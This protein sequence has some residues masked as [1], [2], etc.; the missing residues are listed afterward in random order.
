M[1]SPIVIIFTLVVVAS[2][3]ATVVTPAWTKLLYRYRLGKQIRAAEETPIYSALH[4]KKAGTPTMGGVLIWGTAA[5]LLV[6]LWAVSRFVHHGLLH[7]LNFW[8]RAEI[9]LPA[10]LM[11]LAAVVGLVHDVYNIQQRGA[12][13]GGV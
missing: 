4:A 13:G 9:Y 8:S 2:A 10:G 1:T 6:V 3:L 7:E 5:V 11:L 12:H